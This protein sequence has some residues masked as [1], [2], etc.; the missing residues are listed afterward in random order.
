MYIFGLP[1]FGRK[2]G[3]TIMNVRVC[4]GDGF[5]PDVDLRTAF[6]PHPFSWVSNRTDRIPRFSAI[7]D[8]TLRDRLDLQLGAVTVLAA[9]PLRRNKWSA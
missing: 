8:A 3:L 1:G 7:V 2:S 4:I 9:C 6:P 5:V